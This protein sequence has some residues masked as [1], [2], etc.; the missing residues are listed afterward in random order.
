ME[1]TDFS[2]GE[3]VYLD[4]VKGPVPAKVLSVSHYQRT[5]RVR[6]TATRGSYRRGE[7]VI[8]T[9]RRVFK[10]RRSNPWSEYMGVL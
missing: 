4:S 9:V 5:V 10:R 2:I 1:T 6:V 7:Q 3:L 8:V